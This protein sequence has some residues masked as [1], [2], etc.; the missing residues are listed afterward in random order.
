[1]NC[2]IATQGFARASRSL[3]SAGALLPPFPSIK[4]IVIIVLRIES[5]ILVINMTIADRHV[6][7]E[8]H[9]TLPVGRGVWI[10]V[11]SSGP[12]SRTSGSAAKIS[13]FIFMKAGSMDL[14]R[15]IL[16]STLFTVH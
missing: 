14:R 13:F 6:W 15:G 2:L 11:R 7:R 3:L 8:S 16:S 10:S 4:L 1:M 12:F 9:S 5:I